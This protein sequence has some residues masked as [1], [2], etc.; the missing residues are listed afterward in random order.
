M[1]LSII[2]NRGQVEFDDGQKR[3]MDGQS[4]TERYY[5]KGVGGTM[6]FSA[7]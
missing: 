7:Q 2:I 5:T 1:T 3:K 6:R 4:E